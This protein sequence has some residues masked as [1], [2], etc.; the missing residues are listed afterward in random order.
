MNNNFFTG[1]CILVLAAV[2]AVATI[3][4]VVSTD[5]L[6]YQVE[7]LKMQN[8]ELSDKIDN[9][10]IVA[11][12]TPTVA[13]STPSEP[14]EQAANLQFYDP[15]AQSGGRVISSII[16]DTKNLNYMVNN[17]AT[18]G[19]FW[20]LA[21][22]SL[23]ERNFEH[24]EKFQPLMAKSWS[25]SED[26][27]VYTIKLRKGIYWHDFTDPVTGKEWKN[28]E[29]TAKDFKFMLEV[30][31][32]PDTDTRA[33]KT[34]FKDLD[35]IE[36][37]NDYEFK[38]YW[39]K[40]YFLSKSITLGLSPLPTH[41]YHAYPGPFDGKKFNDDHKRNRLIVGCGPYQFLR[42]EK[43][44]RVLFKR[45]E[46]YFGNKL[47]IMPP[48]KQYA[49]EVIPHPNTRFQALLAGKVDQLGLTPE[50]WMTRTDTKEFGPKGS[51]RK[52]KYPGRGY[53]YIGYNLSD[54]LFKDR[55]VRL[56]L[57]HLVNRER[58]LKEVYFNLGQIITG[59]FFPGS[60]AYDHSIKPY[61]FSIEK[62]KKLLEDVGW[63][64]TDG[65][66]ILDRKGKKFSFTIMQVAN[67]SIQQK[68]LPIIK[69]DMAKAG[70][71]MNIQ[72]VEWSVLL[73][74]LEKKTFQ[75]CTLAWSMGFD[76]DPYQLW[77]SSQA[78]VKSSSNHV[79][80]KNKEA[81][82]LIEEIRV[83][84]DDKKREKLY[85][86][87]HQLIH[88]EQPYT[89]LISPKSLRAINSRY[90]NVKVFPVG[91]PDSIQWVPKDEQLKAF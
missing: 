52:Y 51:I 14:L 58:I 43:G 11:P 39:N 5:S 32:N 90:H 75:V 50:Q 67:S 40:K 85:H 10:Q 34:Y 9:I 37:V 83:T 4:N 65:D 41:F 20:D 66:G 19:M 48:I 45:F 46:R 79:R 91:I 73:Q 38:V 13:K 68:M 7:E 74:R 84:F 53:S 64:D 28:V 17:E 27:K 61:K 87:F 49:F 22:S 57:T 29:V 59:P 3:F 16:A 21:N 42:W 69:E 63:K 76:A 80:F 1:I 71:E 55:R 36:I 30:I 31:K 24:P 26:K 70:I 72:V 35:R 62:A 12:Q 86:K 18:A 77:H 44:Q 81:D 23:A 15:K 8:R 33:H 2:V 89:F 54:P 88:E 82:K 6:R 60:M 47:G 25:I 78:D 56:A